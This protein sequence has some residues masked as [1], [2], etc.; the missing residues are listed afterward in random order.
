MQSP[1]LLRRALV[2]AAVLAC[3]PG[4][5]LRPAAAQSPPPRAP[6]ASQAQIT[7]NYKDADLGQIIEAVSQLTGKN[8]IV[9]PRVKAQVTMLSASPMSPDAFYQ[10]FLALLEVHGFVAVPDGRVVK[11]VPDANAR[12]MPSNDL[13]DHVN[14]ASDELVTQVIGLRNVSAA[15]LVPVL[16][17]LIPQYGHLAAYPPANMLIIS[18]H[19]NNVNRM[20]R[21]IERI[22]QS[23]GD[24]IDIIRLEHASANEVVRVMN[25]LYA[26]Q[27]AGEAGAGVKMVADERSN[28]V[29]VSGEKNAR[30]RLKALITHLDTPLAGAGGETQVR[31]L[32]YADAEKISAKLKEQVTGTAVTPGATAGAAAGGA[33]AGPSSERTTIWADPATNA[34]VITAPTKVMR[35]LMAVVDRLDIRRAQVLLEAIIVDIENTKDMDFGVNWAAYAK[36]G[37][38]PVVTFNEPVLGTA[39]GDILSGVIGAAGGGVSTT[40]GTTTTGSIP[41]LPTGATAGIGRYH[42]GNGVNFA[43]I[44]RALAADAHTNILSMP[45]VTTLDNQEAQIKIAQEV[46]FVT[47]QYTQG[48]TTN[49]STGVVN[50]F[51]TIQRQEV[52]TILKI[53][54]QIT[55]DGTILLK[56]DE[57][58]SA[59]ATATVKTVDVVTN[60]RTIST[61]VLVADQEV[62]VLGGLIEEQLLQSEQR[63]PLLGS[64]PILGNLFK[65]RS[66]TKTKTNLMVFI[67]PTILLD[68]AQVAAET[69]AKYNYLR[70]QQRR[71]TGGKAE[72]LPGEYQPLLPPLESLQ[73]PPGAPRAR[74]YKSNQG[75][76]PGAPTTSVPPAVSVPPAASVAPPASYPPATP[77]VTPDLPMA[78]PLPPPGTGALESTPAPRDGAPPPVV[79]P[80]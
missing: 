15:A 27:A 36:N 47:G 48:S 52:G 18:D 6:A 5:T 69:S 58:V 41:S 17:P 45:T 28:S 3:A 65:T 12:Q 13:P 31:Y 23:S 25:S 80:P 43:A 74:G 14:G 75:L 1:R 35:N 44:V 11:I 8:F 20:M 72:M 59:L 61:K 62:I 9:D 70:E 42:P 64:I 7:P 55:D 32:K 29:L 30:L 60:K 21:I 68:G 54:P 53:T 22:D 51:Q 71:I 34:L 77:V 79:P 38:I 2:V 46:P 37:S 66:T 24:D 40:T 76:N 57:E 67:R 19:A 26:A 16:R 56:I 50:P 39:L 33:S 63:V 10:A 78:P 49:A 4:P 73:P